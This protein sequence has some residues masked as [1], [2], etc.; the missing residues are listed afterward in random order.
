M[1][2]TIT[3]TYGQPHQ[4]SPTNPNH[5]TGGAGYRVSM[6]GILTAQHDDFAEMV[7]FLDLGNGTNL[8][9]RPEGYGIAFLESEEHSLTYFGP[10]EQVREYQRGTNAGENPRLDTSLGFLVGSWPHGGAWDTFIPTSYWNRQADGAAADGVG[11]ITAFAHNAIPGAEVIVYEY[12]GRWTPES[13]V[14][15]LVTYHCT[16][17]HKDAFFDSGHTHANTGPTARRW[18]AQQARQHITSA[19]K[20]G[21]GSERTLCQPHD[22]EAYRIVNAFGREKFGP[23]YIPISEDEGTACATTGPCSIV[24]ELRAGVRPPA[25]PA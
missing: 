3:N 10:I 15:K 23:G 20:H 13:D 17:C 8:H 2:I 9:T 1:S 5:V 12:E 18:A 11:I 21:V 24:R 25:Y 19:T 16:G 22:G 7:D 4:T 14:A 6:A